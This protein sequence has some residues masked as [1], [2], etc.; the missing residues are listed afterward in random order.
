LL[1]VPS[2]NLVDVELNTLT[3]AA[4]QYPF[5]SSALSTFPSISDDEDAL[6][7]RISSLIADHFLSRQ[8]TISPPPPPPPTT[9]TITTKT[10]LNTAQEH[11][12]HSNL[13]DSAISLSTGGSGTIPAAN[14]SVMSNQLSTSI[15][16]NDF[17]KLLHRIRTTVD[18]K[19]SPEIKNHHK[20]K[21]NNLHRAQENNYLYGSCNPL[22]TVTLNRR[23]KLL[24]LHTVSCQETHTDDYN[25]RYS[26]TT[27]ENKHNLDCSFKSQSFDAS[28]L[29]KM[30]DS[31]SSTSF[32]A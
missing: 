28:S 19:L 17:D 20:N 12:R 23:Q 22:E 11:D 4:V 14:I 18:D 25:A 31:M 13:S 16:T 21:N 26:T 8:S 29:S 7:N 27:A 15:L 10:R 6:V 1:V 3:N 32:Y 24:A 5:D 9:I 30:I 2:S